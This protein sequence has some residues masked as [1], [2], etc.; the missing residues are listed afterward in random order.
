[1]EVYASVM[2]VSGYIGPARDAAMH[3]N[4]E[5]TLHVH[6]SLVTVQVIDSLRLNLALPRRNSESMIS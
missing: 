5:L 4:V 6:V 1:M 2:L 3:L